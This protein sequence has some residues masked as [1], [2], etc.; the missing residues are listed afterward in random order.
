MSWEHA[1]FLIECEITRQ[2]AE[3]CTGPIIITLEAG[4]SAMLV[5]FILMK[6]LVF[7]IQMYFVQMCDAGILGGL[8]QQSHVVE[9]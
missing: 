2:G 6:K 4:V 5:A 1:A 8:V 9:M 7:S 3:T